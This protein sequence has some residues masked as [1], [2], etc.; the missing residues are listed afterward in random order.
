LAAQILQE[1]ART[2]VSGR[3]LHAGEAG[4]RQGLNGRRTQTLKLRFL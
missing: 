3:G 4:T 1:G 2:S